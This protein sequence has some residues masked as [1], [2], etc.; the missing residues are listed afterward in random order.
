MINKWIQ[1]NSQSQKV[2]PRLYHEENIQFNP[3]SIGGWGGDKI[4][5]ATHDL[6][7]KYYVKMLMHAILHLTFLGGWGDIFLYSKFK[8]LSM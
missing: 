4:V 7:K 1:I 5:H 3:N 2:K 8:S 6:G